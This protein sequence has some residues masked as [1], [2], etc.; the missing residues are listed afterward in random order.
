V[1]VRTL[2]GEN[3]LSEVV[4]SLTEQLSSV[5]PYHIKTGWR[6]FGHQTK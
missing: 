5:V 4:G 6:Y 2:Q 3:T 1:V